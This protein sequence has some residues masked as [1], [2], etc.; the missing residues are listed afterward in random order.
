MK[1]ML[2]ERHMRMNVDD[3]DDESRALDVSLQ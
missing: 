2:D 1:L 3:V